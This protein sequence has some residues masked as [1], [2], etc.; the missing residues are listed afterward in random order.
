MAVPALLSRVRLGRNYSYSE[1]NWDEKAF[2]VLPDAGLILVP[3]TGDTTNGYASSVQLVDL[4]RDS[5]VARGVIEHAFQPRRA[6][7]YTDRILSISANTMTDG[8]ETV[9]VISDITE[10][11]ERQNQ[12]AHRDRV[13]LVGQIAGGDA[14]DFNN[15]LHVIL[16]YA[17]MLEETLTDP[18]TNP[19][20]R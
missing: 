20:W 16:T 11:R 12:A 18:L 3:F 19:S 9:I 15:L 6:T 1:A 17:N 2:S 7:L 5:V 14:H 8:R 10:E 4:H 13:A